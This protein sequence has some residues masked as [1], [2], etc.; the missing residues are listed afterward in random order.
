MEAKWRCL[1]WTVFLL[2]LSV[3]TTLPERV[4]ES[5]EATQLV[6]RQGGYKV[7]SHLVDTED[8]YVLKVHRVYR[9]NS[10]KVKPSVFMQHGLFASSADFLLTGKSK[11]LAFLLADNDYDVWLGNIRGSR[12]SLRHKRMSTE[13]GK[14]WNFSFHE[15]GL[16]DLPAMIDYMLNVT[17]HKKCYYVGHSQGTTS[18]IV[19]MAMRPEFNEKIIQSHLMAPAV[20]MKNAPHPMIDHLAEIMVGRDFRPYAYIDF[21]PYWGIATRFL[22]SFCGPNMISTLPTCHNIFFA[23]IGSNRPGTVEFD[24]V[25][26]FIE[27]L[28]KSA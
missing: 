17:R 4:N 24:D 20:F 9:K 21:R 23:V 6:R 16:Y 2:Q 28:L 13:S 25:R 10:K 5:D 14:Y 12:N 1:L 11:A 15:F 22:K 8:G 27:S 18:F 26:K 3:K 19:M 7:E